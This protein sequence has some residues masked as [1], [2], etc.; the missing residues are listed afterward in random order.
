LPLSIYSSVLGT[1]G[2]VITIVACAV[3]ALALIN[4]FARRWLRHRKSVRTLKRET[5]VSVGVGVGR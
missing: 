1:I 2:V 5:R 4:R 3:L